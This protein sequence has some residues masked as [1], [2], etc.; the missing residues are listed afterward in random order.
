VI[1]IE[2]YVFRRAG[3]PLGWALTWNAIANTA[4]TLIGIPAT[5]FVLWGLN[6]LIVGSEC[7]EPIRTLGERIVWTAIRAPWLC[8]TGEAA[9]WTVPLAF[10]FLLV[11]FFLISWQ[12]ESLIIRLANKRRDPQAIDRACLRANLTTYA[13]LS[14]Y[15]A[16]LY[17]VPF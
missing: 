5:W 7:G 9:A 16:L 6:L 15:A 4:T 14:L 1:L 12:I 11:P 2:T 8:P 10:L 3:F 17:A 13:L